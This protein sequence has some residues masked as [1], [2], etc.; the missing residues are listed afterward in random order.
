MSLLEII[1][2]GMS[3]TWKCEN[4]NFILAER[5]CCSKNFRCR[6]ENNLVRSLK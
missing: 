5:F 4:C 6:S 3:V 1:D 2:N